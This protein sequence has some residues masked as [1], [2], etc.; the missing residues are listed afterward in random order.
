MR[1]V[2]ILFWIFV[3]LWCVSFVAWIVCIA[4][5]KLRERYAYLIALIIVNIFNVCVVITNAISKSC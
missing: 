4:V 5:P 1:P 3:A 2:E